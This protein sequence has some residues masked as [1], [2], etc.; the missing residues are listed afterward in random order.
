MRA[1]ATAA[2]ATTAAATTTATGVGNFLLSRHATQFEGQADILADLLLQAFKGLLGGHEIAGNV[3]VKQR[4][5]GGF[6]FLDLRGTQLNTSVLLVM[7]LLAALMNA[8]VLEAGSIIVEEKLNLFLKLD[9][10]RIAGD[11]RTE[12]AGFFD[13]R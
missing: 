5:T 8:L 7:Q 3:I 11:L 9:E 1:A 4:I 12:L 2:T 13:D 10:G 6:E